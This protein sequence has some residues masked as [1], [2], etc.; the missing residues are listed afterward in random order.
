MT[1]IRSHYSHQS[2]H[3][4][5]ISLFKQSDHI[6]SISLFTPIR[7]HQF[8]LIIHTNPIPPIRSDYL[9]QSDHHICLTLSLNHLSSITI[10]SNHKITTIF[11]TT[12][13]ITLPVN[14]TRPT[15]QITSIYIHYVNLHHV[16]NHDLDK[17]ILSSWMSKNPI[18]HKQQYQINNLQHHNSFITLH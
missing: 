9:L 6:N 10:L 14:I 12:I 15:N 3:I 8:D 18:Q 2:D 7:S 13:I 17:H 5:S 16:L 11:P 1:S 4:K